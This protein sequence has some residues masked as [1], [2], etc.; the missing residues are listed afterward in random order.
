[1]WLRKV[2]SNCKVVLDFKTC[3]ARDRSSVERSFPAKYI[4]GLERIRG[5]PHV[6]QEGGSRISALQKG[7]PVVGASF[8]FGSS[9]LKWREHGYRV[10][11]A[12]IALRFWVSL[13]RARNAAFPK[14]RLRQC[15]LKAGLRL[16]IY[17]HQLRFLRVSAS[18]WRVQIKAGLP[19]KN[20]NRI[21]EMLSWV[22]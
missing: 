15:T 21:T 2:S 7:R 5:R 12:F 17:L 8:N 14:G 10:R 20:C 9:T 16:G 13:S 3:V 11:Q 18:R 19:L 1:M 4:S 22:N 6:R